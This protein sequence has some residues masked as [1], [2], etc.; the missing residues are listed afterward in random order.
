[1]KIQFEFQEKAIRMLKAGIE[2][3]EESNQV[4]TWSHFQDKGDRNGILMPYFVWSL[5]VT[6]QM[7]L[8]K[9]NTN[10]NKL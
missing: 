5:S 9:P 8:M 10:V 1:M 7:I 3:L 6:N 2:E 4:R